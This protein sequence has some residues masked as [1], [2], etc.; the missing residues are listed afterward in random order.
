MFY[1]VRCGACGAS[2]DVVAHNVAH[3][4][5]LV[6]QMHAP[7]HS[8]FLGAVRDEGARGHRQ[9]VVSHITRKGVILN[10]DSC[11]CQECQNVQ[12]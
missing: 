8:G 4:T 1:V 5:A 12:S 6:G 3:A 7:A 2:R 9:A 11:L 10:T